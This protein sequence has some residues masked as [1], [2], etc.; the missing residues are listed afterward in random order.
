M[1][2]REIEALM[3]L[4]QRHD[5]SAAIPLPAGFIV[6]VALAVADH[7]ELSRRDADIH[8]VPE[9]ILYTVRKNIIS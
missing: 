3:S 2:A 7:V 4:R 8:S 5:V 9:L 1:P 6:I